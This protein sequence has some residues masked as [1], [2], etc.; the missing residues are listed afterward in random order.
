MYHEK[1]ISIAP[2]TLKTTRTLCNCYK[3]NVQ[4]LIN[5]KLN[6][7]L[8]IIPTGLW[9]VWF[10]A[11][12]LAKSSIR[13]LKFSFLASWLSVNNM[14]RRQSLLCDMVDLNFFFFFLLVLAFWKLLAPE[15]VKQ[16][17]PFQICSAFA[18][19]ELHDFFCILKATYPNKLPHVWLP[20]FRK[21]R[22]LISRYYLSNP[23]EINTDS[24]NA[25]TCPASQKN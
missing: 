15:T 8:P 21:Q 6:I 16:F 11:F 12:L 24:L 9:L 25:S 18:G 7:T 23:C 13:S 5:P 3:P 4:D 20:D 2:P 22:N 14:A 10:T 17:T 19:H 1:K